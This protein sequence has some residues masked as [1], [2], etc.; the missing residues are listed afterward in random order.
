[1]RPYLLALAAALSFAAT[2]HADDQVR[3]MPAFSSIS[4]TG[5]ISITVDAGKAQ[6][7]TL[8]GDAR[9]LQDV[10]SEVVERVRRKNEAELFTKSRK[11]A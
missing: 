2:A 4:V 6:S 3:N 7:V 1:M 8:R 11:R 10:T 5:P 9:F